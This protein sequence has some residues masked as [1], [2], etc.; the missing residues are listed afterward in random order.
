MKL[1]EIQE[2]RMRLGN[3]VADRLGQ[4]RTLVIQAEDARINDM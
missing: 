2:T 3:D 1:S 4:V